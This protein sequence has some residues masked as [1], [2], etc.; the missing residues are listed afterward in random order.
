MDSLKTLMDKKQY[1]LVI[2]LTENSN[3][4]VALFYRLSAL[5]A[6]GQSEEALKLIQNKRLILQNRLDILIKV[7]LEIL[8][9]LGRFDEAY[10]ELRYYQELPY[11][12]QVVEEILKAMPDYIRKEE[13][14]SYGRREKNEKQI[15]SLLMSENDEEVLAAFDAIKNEPLNSYL[16]PILKIMRSHP[17][18]V[19]RSFALLLLV[20]HKYDKEVD[21]LD[22]GNLVKVVPSSLEEPFKIP[23]YK[24][25]QDFS[26]VLQ[27]TYHDPSVVNNAMNIISSYLIYIYPHQ[28]TLNKEESLIVF[29][30]LAKRL[31]RID[32][33]DLPDMCDKYQLDY[34]KIIQEIERINE[35]LKNF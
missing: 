5:V 17:R 32:D 11:E 29:G 21:F 13:K 26:F 33:Q 19:I 1:D 30:Y 7:H 8:C 27:S 12:S 15:V 31:L 10:E 9:L 4:S 24:D 18:Q 3:D 23:G 34:Q 28:L 16:L 22:N 35:V 20:N 2:K 6:V 14:N 25:L